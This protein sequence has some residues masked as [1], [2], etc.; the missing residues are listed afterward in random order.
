MME[1]VNAPQAGNRVQQPV[2]PVVET[3]AHEDR[4]ADLR[5]RRPAARPERSSERCAHP[6]GGACGQS[7][8]HELS[9]ALADQVLD[10]R[11]SQV[12]DA[13]GIGEGLPVRAAWYQLRG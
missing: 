5:G 7:Q 4:E 2:V 8:D 11:V 3:V 10:D 1:R 6:S 9:E 12:V 13:L